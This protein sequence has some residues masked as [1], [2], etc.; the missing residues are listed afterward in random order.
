MKV[1]ECERV[2]LLGCTSWAAVPTSPPT[3]TSHCVQTVPT[4][5]KLRSVHYVQSSRS[6]YTLMLASRI[7]AKSRVWLLLSLQ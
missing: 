4:V 3:R 6:W 5:C 1:G 7:P 2:P